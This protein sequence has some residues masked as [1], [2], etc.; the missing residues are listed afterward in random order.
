MITTNDLRLA[1]L[2]RMRPDENVTWMRVTVHKAPSER[3]GRHSVDRNVHCVFRLDSPSLHLLDVVQPKVALAEAADANHC[4]YLHPSTHSM[5]ITRLLSLTPSALP[6]TLG[7]YTSPA[8]SGV[9][10]R[11]S[12]HLRAFDASCRKDVSNRICSDT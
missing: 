3:H 9:A 4:T 11:C 8:S 5:T 6:Y 12:A 10:A 2:G 7:T 1:L